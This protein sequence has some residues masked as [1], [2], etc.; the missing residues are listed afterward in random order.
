MSAIGL[1]V[2][3]GVA[4]ID[5]NHRFESSVPEDTVVA[6]N[7]LCAPCSAFVEK[8]TLLKRLGRKDI[9]IGAEEFGHV[10][11]ARDLK[12]GYGSGECHFC[13][14]LWLRAGGS[15][16]DPEKLT[17]AIDLDSPL[18][19]RLSAR[20]VE[21]EY[22]IM[23][24]RETDK[25]KKLWYKI[26][27]MPPISDNGYLDL[28]ILALNKDKVYADL[29][30]HH[31]SN[32][33][34]N[35]ATLGF[36]SSPV[37]ARHSDNFAQIK[38]WL[39]HC[40]AT[41]TRCREL[42]DLV[43]PTAQLPSRL[44]DVSSGAIKLDC[45]LPDSGPLPYTTLSHMWGTD[46][47]ACPQLLLSTLAEFE[48]SIDIGALPPK[49][50]YA[51]QITRA[52]GYRYI[53]I[54][55]LCIIQDSPQD[56]QTE[57]LKMAGVYGRSA[58]NISY[59]FPPDKDLP[60]NYIR[61]PRVVLPCVVP[62]PG[63]KSKSKSDEEGKLVISHRPG[64]NRPAWSPTV[65]KQIWPLLSRGWVFQERLLCSK[66]V[67][68]GQDRLLWE[69]CE[70]IVDEYF[71]PLTTVPGSKSH[72]HRVITGLAEGLGAAKEVAKG[73]KVERG[74]GEK[75][76]VVEY[77]ED[78]SKADEQWGPLVRD[79]RAGELT[80]EFDRGIAFAGIARAIQASAGV[81]YLAGLWKELFAFDLLWTTGLVVVSDEERAKAEKRK[82]EAKPA[83]SWSWFSVVPTAS[84]MG[85][86]VLGW[87]F[88]TT[89]QTYRKHALF[90]AAVV[91]FEHPKIDTPDAL[92]HDFDGMTVTLRAKRIP[93]GFEWWDQFDMLCVLPFGDVKWIMG[94]HENVI[95]G[96]AVTPRV[97]KYAH[98]DATVKKGDV[99]P[100]GACMVLT[101]EQA[102]HVDPADPTKKTQGH[103]KGK[104]IPEGWT[105]SYQ[106]AGIVV[107]PAGVGG[108]ERE[109][110]RRVGA[111]MLF[112]N[113]TG[114][115][116]VGPFDETG[117][118][119][120]VLV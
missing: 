87:P 109:T 53:W 111:F 71:G 83:P 86:D 100:E 94:K 63:G 97:L 20:D 25:T 66:T 88:R 47:S 26:A 103:V 6:L 62:T 90:E 51:I 61:D 56:W 48:S 4:K 76:A 79:Y 21:K 3:D 74:K 42:P 114:H 11:T 33:K 34:L 39:D 77:D 64:F 80:K 120:I 50:A 41:H 43:A 81:T 44:L 2:G 89:M 22:E 55:S 57:A 27:S 106:Y 49:Y 73:R 35:T 23:V 17:T 10:G 107:V 38:T 75:F 108:K 112:D 31:S 99:L 82:L 18:E 9:K 8:S 58:L 119:D 13:A 102:W 16:F 117:E 29:H 7:K 14:L 91:G 28:R 118:E 52:L 70:E 85:G 68:F 1:D 110:W 116:L 78:Q 12:A 59:V 115:E 36:T 37:S 54:D 15:H 105:T 101:V 93:C 65:Y 60:E 45:S 30:I 72:F 92:L 104:E 46:P 69:C 113:I 5:F 67:Y 95:G 84:K 24:A 32:P 98:D 96:Q 40:T 19:V